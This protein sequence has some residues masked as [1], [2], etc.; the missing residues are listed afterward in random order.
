MVKKD[1]VVSMSYNLKNAAGEE[2]GSADSAKPLTYLQGSG[3]IVPGL[4][5]ALE[6]LVIGDKKDVTLTAQEGYGELNPELKMKVERKMFPPDAEIKA[7]MQFRANI[8]GD[9]EHTFTVM[10]V[11]NDDVFVDGNHP[12]AGQTLH[13][14]VEIVGIREATQEEL[15][16]GHAHGPDGTH[17]H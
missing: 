17:S 4:E 15:T 3:Q 10:D 8:G 14:S 7:G 9:R 6:G 11:Q 13:F 5:N 16:H 2:L 1:S 12:L